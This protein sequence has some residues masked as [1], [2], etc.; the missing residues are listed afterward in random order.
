MCRYDYAE[1]EEEEAPIQYEEEYE[2]RP[3]VNYELIWAVRAEF[4]HLNGSHYEEEL[5]NAS[6]IWSEATD[7]TIISLI[8]RV[9]HT[10][11][12]NLIK[13]DDSLYSPT[14]DDIS[15]VIRDMHREMRYCFSGNI[16]T[17]IESSY[18]ACRIVYI[19]KMLSDTPNIAHN[20]N[21]LV[22]YETRVADELDN[23]W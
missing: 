17:G 9:K 3:H 14:F 12:S 18:D 1:I 22:D 11:D 13:N 6:R 19:S 2:E 21:K 16:L 10:F 7:E 15:R 5:A 20:I 8:D 23:S 4:G